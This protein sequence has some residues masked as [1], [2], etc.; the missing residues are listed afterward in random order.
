MIDGSERPTGRQYPIQAGRYAA[1]VTEVGAGLRS[2]R[3]KDREL[4]MEFPEHEVPPGASGQLLIPWPN[5][6]RDGRY[7]FEG[8]ERRLEITEPARDNAIHGLTRRLPWTVAAHTDSSVRL[9]LS[10]DPQPGYPFQLDLTAQYDL[11]ENDGLTITVTA[12]NAGE[13]NAPYGIGSHAYLKVDGGLDGPQ[14]LLRVPAGEWVTV[15]ER[16]LPLC[17]VPVAGTPYDFRDVRSLRGVTL[18]IAF[19]EIWRDADGR[20]RVTLGRGA[21][22]ATLWFGEGLEWVQLFS[23]DPLEPPYH[24]AALAVEPM[25]CP[26]NAF[27]E[28]K[29][30]IVLAPGETVAHTW[31]IVAGGA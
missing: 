20:A 30:L 17:D 24:R 8:V 2:L 7:T 14:G 23:G 28:G 31:G 5:R 3:L 13:S 15:D 12:R 25:S 1:V 19:T 29:G 10:L 9:T 4:V 26:A 16:L 27:V 18:D 22:G 11:D 6:I 21:E